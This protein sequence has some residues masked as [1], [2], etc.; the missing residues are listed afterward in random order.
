MV[1]G[2]QHPKDSSLQMH[3][4]QFVVSAAKLPISQDAP[5][6]L[7]MRVFATDEVTAKTKFWKNLI[8]FRDTTLNGAV[9]QLHM[10]MAG[11]HRAKFDTIQIIRTTTLTK[12]NIIRRPKSLEMRDSKLKFPII[13]TIH[14]HSDRKYRKVYQAQR[15]KTYV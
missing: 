13:K 14:R 5:E 4:R 3:I 7:Q 9:S 6:I 2:S 10:E 15:P 12:R 8:K 11:N 1:K